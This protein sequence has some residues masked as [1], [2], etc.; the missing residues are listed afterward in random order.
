M[1]QVIKRTPEQRR[2]IVEKVQ[3]LIANGSNTTAACEA[4]GVN[5]SSYYGW[6]EQFKEKRRVIKRA[7]K[8][9]KPYMQEVTPDL[10]TGTHKVACI[11]G[12]PQDISAV[13]RGMS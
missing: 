8:N 12:S 5:I 9:S 3:E 7:V 13:L 11:I 2:E 1:R 6:R 10:P 4:M